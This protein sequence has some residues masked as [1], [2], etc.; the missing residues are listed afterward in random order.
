MQVS[1][2]QNITLLIHLNQGFS[3]SKA[4][5]KIYTALGACPRTLYETKTEAR[6]SIYLLPDRQN[7]QFQRF[8]K[9]LYKNSHKKLRLNRNIVNAFTNYS[10]VMNK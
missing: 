9:F 7:L 2:E 3:S 5:S 4:A 1:P 6:I 10:D 8:Y